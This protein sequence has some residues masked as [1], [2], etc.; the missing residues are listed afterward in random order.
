M[1]YPPI[2]ASS[3][4]AFNYKETV[5]IYFAIS[6]YNTLNDIAQVQMTVRYQH[7]NRN[8]LNT[9]K[10]PNRIKC[11][12][13][14]EVRPEDDA[15]IAATAARY[16]IELSPS[17]LVDGYFDPS[18]LYKVQLRF[19]STTASESGTAANLSKNAS[20]WSTVCLLKP[21][22]VPNIYVLQLGGKQFTEDVQG[23]TVSMVY[24]STESV[25]NILYQ[26]QDQISDEPLKT[27]RARLYNSSKSQLYADSDVQIVNSYESSDNKITI[28]CSLPYTMTSNTQYCLVVDIQTRNG[29]TK[30][31]EFH[32][33]A[34]SYAVGG[35]EG[36]LSLHINQNDGY[37]QV[38]LESANQET[39][40]TNVTFR[41]TSSKS[42]FKIWEDIANYTIENGTLNIEFDDFTI[43]SG[44]FYQYSVQIRDNR[45][46]R[47]RSIISDQ[48]MGQ[49][50]DAF[51]TEKGG[52]LK[53]ALQLKIKY[54]MNISNSVVNVGQ[55]KTDTIGSK[56]PYIRRNGNMYYHS[57]P[58]SFLIAVEEDDNHL[59]AKEDELRDNVTSMYAEAYNYA[60]Q[61]GKK[62]VVENG[63]YDYT[64]QREFRR[65]VESFLYNNKVKLF[66]SATE[67]NMLI[68][69]MSIT[70]TPNQDLD[71]LLY[72]VDATAYEI[73]D[74]TLINID[75]YGIQQIGT[76]NPNITFNEIKVGQ[77]NRIRTQLKDDGTIEN[78]EDPFPAL[79]T[80]YNLIGTDGQPS[81]IPNIKTMFH[82][83][84]S[85]DGIITS[86]F[87]L[88]YL[89]I[90]INSDPYLIKN[91]NGILTPLEE[92]EQVNE[93]TLLG[94]LI[95][96]CGTTV[97]IKYPNTI[98]EI[99]G[100]NVR[101]SA[102]DIIAPIK[103][104]KMTV[105]FIVYLSEEADTSTIASTLIYTDK[106][107]QLVQTFV[108][109]RDFCKDITNK[110]YSD[111]YQCRNVENPY[112]TKVNTIFNLNIQADPGTIIYIAG[113]ENFQ[114]QKF[115]I[116]ETGILF[117]DPSVD[118]GYI[119]KAYFY[120]VNVT[121]DDEYEISEQARDKSPKQLN[122][123]TSQ[124]NN[125][126]FYYNGS[127]KAGEDQGD[128]INYAIK[129]DDPISA[130]VEYYIEI[131]KGIY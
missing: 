31:R 118:D 115:V 86:D 81:N 59:F 79:S 48:L 114:P 54:N 16:Y 100:D 76:Y 51:L 87:Y 85:A 61:G 62:L 44:V 13:F 63:Q 124:D 117:I 68:K 14:T 109:G 89:R 5:R 22:S 34:I 69:L 43:E 72:S 88:S 129:T 73:D 33:T 19:S 66:R 28:Q 7:N 26:P 15:A 105:D 3:A 6:T 83:N 25:F 125:V 123:Y 96:I 91:E 9:S 127:W 41:R 70:L 101:I 82:W 42:N 110:Y 20:E 106:V 10:Y 119:T 12:N 67:G 131:E 74:P 55:A 113:S 38:K 57:F 92:G 58:F 30:S 11:C 46:R 60:D 80:G 126:Y 39:V 122:W 111:F 45:G 121:K 21:I 130:I 4:P 98:Y 94:T 29:Y 1:L 77:L 95:N 17:D 23:Q 104:T 116:D 97:L 107:G 56:Y 47:S 18:L 102:N 37:A 32:F 84:H 112:Y 128:G 52:N 53:D 71:R 120:G 108:P 40:H 24:P 65:K 49:F 75:K 35:I 103:D 50:E 8:A 27:W 99:K 36:R 78:I 2:L 90:E 93:N 64:Y